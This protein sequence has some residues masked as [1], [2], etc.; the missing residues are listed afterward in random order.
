MSLLE[1]TAKRSGISLIIMF[2]ISIVIFSI[3][4]LVPGDPAAVLAGEFATAEGVEA[5]RRELG[6]HLPIWEQYMNW[7]G[8]ILIGEMGKSYMTDQPVADLLLVRYPRSLQLTIGGILISLLI[9]FPAGIFA[10]VKRNTKY[11]YSAMFFSQVGVSIPSFWLGLMF[12]LL[13]GQYLDILP[14]SGYV[15]FTEDPIGSLIRT[16]M[17]ALTLG[18]INGAVITRFLRS[19]MLEEFSQ[20]YIRTARAAGISEAKIVG[21]YT[22]KNA[23][24]PTLTII[25]LQVGWLLGGV[26]IVEAVFAWPGVGTLILKAIER[27]DY[28]VIQ[29][30]L[31]ALASTFVVVNL[32]VD[33]LHAWVDPKIKY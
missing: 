24:I 21:K 1:Y 26:V 29:M 18:I 15:P 16:L 12:I 2:G 11:D 5:V 19:S 20:D 13:F 9:A 6:L 22:L 32:I 33:L 7:I 30:G 23:L 8:G 4:R 17:P 3:V 25:G 28:P 10:S 27:R 31:L 14:P